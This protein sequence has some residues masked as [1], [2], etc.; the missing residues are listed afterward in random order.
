MKQL[1]FL[2]QLTKIK[3]GCKVR[4]LVEQ[5]GEK[6]NEDNLREFNFNFFFFYDDELE[7]MTGLFLFHY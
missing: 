7:S 1:Y 6:T 3:N 2:I 5:R 4:L